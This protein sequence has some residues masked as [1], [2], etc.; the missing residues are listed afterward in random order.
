MTHGGH[1]EIIEN[2]SLL[3][4]GKISKCT[5]TLHELKNRENKEGDIV[6]QREDIYQELRILGYE[7]K[8]KFQGLKQFRMNGKCC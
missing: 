7:Y 3:A 6:L 2:E 4:E 8:Q 1:F 5:E